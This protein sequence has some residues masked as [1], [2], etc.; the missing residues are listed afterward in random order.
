MTKAYPNDHAPEKDGDKRYW[1]DNMRN[2]YKL[3]WAL[4]VLCGLLLFSDV[5]YKKHVVF[6]FEHWFGFFGLFGFFVS[7][8]LVLT[9]RE[10]RK[11]LMRGED[12]YD[13]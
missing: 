13:R 10:L 11:I 1:L 12:Y 6:E 7:F 9:A 4:V 3:F 2:V 5:F 8:A